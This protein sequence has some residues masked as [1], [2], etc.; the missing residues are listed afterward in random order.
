[1]R[2]KA[3][4]S[5]NKGARSR[6][7]TDIRQKIDRMSRSEWREWYKQCLTEL[8]SDRELW[9]WLNHEPKWISPRKGKYGGKVGRPFD[10]QYLPDTRH[11]EL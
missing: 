2:P 10:N 9:E 8:H 1:M 4:E 7:Y 11:G 3:P 6:Y 5:R